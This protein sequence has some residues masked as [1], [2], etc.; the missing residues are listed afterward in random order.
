M[1]LK[2]NINPISNA[3]DKVSKI[4]GYT[5]DW[6]KEHLSRFGKEDNYFNRKND[7]GV[8]AQEIQEVLPEVVAERKDKT[9]AV[10][11]DKLVPLLIESIKELKTELD[12]L[13]SSK[14]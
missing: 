3:L 2:E 7:V 4:G 12:E 10:K 14:I 8:M 11:Y 9:L 1:A 5:F 13:K 6:T